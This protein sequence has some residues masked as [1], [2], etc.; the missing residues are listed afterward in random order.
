MRFIVLMMTEDREMANAWD[1][2]SLSY[3][4]RYQIGT[5][6]IH[7]G[8][9][10]P[11]EDKL[12]LLG[13]VNGKKVIEIG[14]GAGQNSIVLAKQ[15]AII[16]ALDISK[17]QLEHGKKIAREE[18]VKLDFIQGDFQELR[19]YFNSNSFEVAMSAYA[20]QYCSTLESMK[21][22]FKQIHEILTPEGIFV[23]SLDHP[24]RTIGYWEEGTD[25][26]VLDN[27]FDRS[28]K[29]WDYT[30]PETG[31]SARMKGS[32]RT[33]SDIVNGVLQ[34]GFRL[35]NILEPEPVNHDDNS[36]FG[37]NSKYGSKNKKDPYSFNH[38]SRIPG[39]LIIK[40]R[41]Y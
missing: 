36:Q 21:K 9:L 19:K 2:I 4:R 10:C 18:N 6:K 5:S 15:G 35:E 8:P 22:T 27:Y 13:N 25:R 1:K 11:S 24:V 41:K 14:S 26:F 20:L 32:F 34:A 38:L 30:F 31:V 17:E 3:Q 33:V 37:I 40:A 29:E 23:F 12:G 39:T 7:W 28:Q 16:T